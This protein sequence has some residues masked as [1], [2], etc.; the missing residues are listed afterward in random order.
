M[1]RPHIQ[2]W[3]VGG[4]LAIITLLL[5]RWPLLALVNGAIGVCLG[6]MLLRGPRD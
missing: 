3:I 5:L 2:S 6:E 1:R 4:V